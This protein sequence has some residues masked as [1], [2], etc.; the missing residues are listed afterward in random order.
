MPATEPS[1]LPPILSIPEVA[2][3]F[4]W[5]PK[6]LY[7]QIKKGRSPV[8]VVKVGGRYKVLRTDLERFL[9]GENVEAV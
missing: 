5:H 1:E 6:T 4:G 7:K 9:A 8:R 2:V 3:V